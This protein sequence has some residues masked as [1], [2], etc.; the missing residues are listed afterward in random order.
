[1][2][3]LEELI[4]ELPPS[5]RE[6]PGVESLIQQVER[7]KE[8]ERE[9][10]GTEHRYGYK[11]MYGMRNR[12][13]ATLNSEKNRYKQALDELLYHFEIIEFREDFADSIKRV[14]AGDT[15]E[16]I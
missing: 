15:N 3:R 13:Y 10:N 11:Q 16:N 7:V 12:D 4:E 14:L 1:M 8:L 2:S 9:L 6:Y 5:I